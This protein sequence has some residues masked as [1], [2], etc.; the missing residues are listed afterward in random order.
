[1]SDLAEHIGTVISIVSALLAVVGILVTV[2][3]K[4]L[5]KAIGEAKTEAKK[6]PTWLQE[7]S[8]R[9]GVITRDDHFSFCG[10]ERAKCP[11]TNLV[12]WKNELYEKGGPM[13]TA[14]HASLCKEVAKQMSEGFG[15]ELNHSRE[16][17]MVE[18][19]LIQATIKNDVVAEI[20][21]IKEGL[22]AK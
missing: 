10:Y 19:K 5:R 1:M 16:L 20:R 12:E 15:N 17:M 11:I 14:D 7:Q 2:I 8:K 13:L 9:G 18:L 22:Q 6:F 21:G 4:D 3:W